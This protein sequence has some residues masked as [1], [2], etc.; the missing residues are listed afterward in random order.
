MDDVS[1]GI[2]A[3]ATAHRFRNPSRPWKRDRQST[4]GADCQISPSLRLQA[5]AIETNGFSRHDGVVNLFG[6][7]SHDCAVPAPPA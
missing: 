2:C 4:D 6:Q 5:I 1:G 3:K 7:H